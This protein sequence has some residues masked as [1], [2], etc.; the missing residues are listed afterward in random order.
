MLI[1][2]KKHAFPNQFP[3]REY[4]KLPRK[5]GHS[6]GMKALKTRRFTLVTVVLA[7]ALAVTFLVSFV[8]GRYPIP[9]RETVAILW[10][11]IL[12]G[13]E[14]LLDWI[15]G[16]FK[17]QG[18][19]LGLEQF[20][21]KPMETLMLNVRLPRILLA[22]L[23]GACLSAAGA[24]YQGIFQN[25]MAS[26]D[27][28]GASK[29][30]GFGAAL[31][32]WLGLGSRMVSI[33]AFVF[34]LGAVALVWLIGRNAHGKQVLALVLAGIMISSLFDAGTSFIKLVA[35]PTDQLPAI[36]YWMMGS[37]SSARMSD[38]AFALIPMLLGMVCLLLLRWH[39][40]VLTL[41]DDEARTMGINAK[42][43]RLAVALAATLITAAAVAVS[44]VI[45]WVGLVVPHLARKLVGNNY[46]HLMPCS[47]LLGAL[48]L[49]VVDNLSRN[50]LATEIP[51]GI[52][53]AIVG[54]P[55]FI[56]LI[57]RGGEAS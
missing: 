51:L 34:A 40:N 45:G 31:G 43:V 44:G 20:W 50:L 22:C 41:G 11:A 32:I 27:I 9:L 5:K 6:P 21:T 53:T 38:V 49:L 42:A 14:R 37:L 54:A 8:L 17:A 25:P 26:P 33:S 10:D 1:C 47:M 30:A 4:A 12:E 24:A 52:L 13:V 7:V 55:F 15:C 56:Y 19:D 35:D 2:K 57:M 23:V 28:L 36:T 48:F 39:I 16:L 18:P 29:G 3:E 46:R